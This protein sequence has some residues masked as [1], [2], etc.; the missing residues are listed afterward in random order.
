MYMIHSNKFAVIQIH[1]YARNMVKIEAKLLH[2]F[3]EGIPH[4]QTTTKNFIKIFSKLISSN[5]QKSPARLKPPF[6][7]R[8]YNQENN[9]LDFSV[10]NMRTDICNYSVAS[11]L[12]T[13]RIT[14]F[15]TSFSLLFVNKVKKII[16]IVIFM[17]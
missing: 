1:T 6:S 12:K 13:V 15:V 17:Y 4:I 8:G 5:S 9:I 16:I 10:S 14:Y 3:I 2:I 7:H 11:L